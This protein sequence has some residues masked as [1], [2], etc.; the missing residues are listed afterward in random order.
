[1][2][3]RGGYREKKVERFRK[4]RSS[5][6]KSILL[7]LF[8]RRLWA[9]T[10]P[11]CEPG[12]SFN[13]NEGYQK[14]HPV[15]FRPWH[16]LHRPELDSRHKRSNDEIHASQPTPTCEPFDVAKA[17]RYSSAYRSSE[18]DEEPEIQD[19]DGYRDGVCG[20]E[21]WRAAQ[22]DAIV[23]L[24]TADPPRWLRH[25]AYGEGN[26]DPEERLPGYF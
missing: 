18:G 7:C 17:A 23:V 3:Q 11:Q 4:C 19:L 2:Y 22:P 12:E 20:T 24:H 5:P 6:P 9:D 14:H 21:D 25:D 13:E 8:P 26:E 15:S 10:I 1:M 16:A